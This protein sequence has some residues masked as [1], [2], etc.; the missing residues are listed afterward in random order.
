[1]A[2]DDD[3]SSF[4]DSQDN[5]DSF[6]SKHLDTIIDLFHELQDRFPYMFGSMK[7]TVLTDLILV[8]C[9]LVS[10]ENSSLQMN[11]CYSTVLNNYIKDY[12]QELQ[13]SY[14]LLCMY[15]D[16]TKIKHNLSTEMWFKFCFNYCTIYQ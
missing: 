11:N 2:S 5:L 7:S 4:E 8:S 3:L 16:N 1:M 14:W 12:N 13:S 6:L 9:D 15:L 10:L